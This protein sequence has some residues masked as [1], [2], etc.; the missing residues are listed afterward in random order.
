MYHT[1]YI[2]KLNSDVCFYVIFILRGFLDLKIHD[3]SG[4]YYICE[5]TIGGAQ[6]CEMRELLKKVCISVL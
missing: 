6:Y 3:A 4:I 1:I 2:D 5:A